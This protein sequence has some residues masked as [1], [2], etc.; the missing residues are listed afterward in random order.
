MGCK[1]IFMS[2]WY[3]PD[4]VL[5]GRKSPWK[6]VLCSSFSCDAASYDERSSEG[7]GSLGR[8]AASVWPN[9]P[10]LYSDEPPALFRY[11]HLLHV[12]QHVTA[13]LASSDFTVQS[14]SNL[15]YLTL[16]LWF[17][18]WVQLQARASLWRPC[19][20]HLLSLC[21]TA[22]PL[23]VS[24][25]A[26]PLPTLI[27]CLITWRARWGGWT[28]VLFYR[29]VVQLLSNVRHFLFLLFTKYSKINCDHSQKSIFMVF[30]LMLQT[31]PWCCLDCY[32]L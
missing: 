23:Q 5:L 19:P 18:P 32:E 27:R 7:H 30:E 22:C 31:F 24:M 12:T 16:L 21:L 3:P 14:Y 29:Y 2:D 17:P 26:A 25:A 28:W 6:P 10:R 15:Y 13:A 1:M 8:R 9:E 11:T 20:S 4:S